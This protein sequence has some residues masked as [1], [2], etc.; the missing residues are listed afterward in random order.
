VERRSKKG[1]IFYGCNGYPA[2]DFVSWDKPAP[3]PCPDCGSLMVEKH[4]RGRTQ[5]RC[6]S[7]GHGEDAPEVQDE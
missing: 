2:C 5:W 6:T 3:K 4:A 7:C 1:R